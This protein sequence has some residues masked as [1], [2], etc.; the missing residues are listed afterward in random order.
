MDSLPFCVTSAPHGRG[1]SFIAPIKNGDTQVAAFEAADVTNRRASVRLRQEVPGCPAYSRNNEADKP[2]RTQNHNP[3]R[4]LHNRL[5][6]VFPRI[7]LVSASFARYKYYSSCN[8]NDIKDLPA[9]ANPATP[10]KRKPG[11][12]LPG[13]RDKNTATGRRKKTTCKGRRKRT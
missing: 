6:S 7:P 5:Q 2:E 10:V 13:N 1:A 4:M 11:R 8:K 12:Q 3:V 9:S